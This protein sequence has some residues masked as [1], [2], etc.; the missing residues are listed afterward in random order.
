MVTLSEI[1]LESP[2]LDAFKQKHR[3]LADGGHLEACEKSERGHQLLTVVG[4]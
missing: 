3:V 4:K 1:Y 2:T